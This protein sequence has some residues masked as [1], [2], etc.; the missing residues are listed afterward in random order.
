M[1]C[2]MASILRGRWAGEARRGGARNG[3]RTIA[4]EHPFED[5][6]ATFS[7]RRMQLQLTIPKGCLA[8]DQPTRQDDWRPVGKMLRQE[9]P[10]GL[11]GAI[12]LSSS[13]ALASCQTKTL[14]TEIRDE[15]DRIVSAVSF[16]ASTRGGYDRTKTA[17]AD[18]IDHK[19]TLQTV[20]VTLRSWTGCNG[21]IAGGKLRT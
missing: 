17:Q 1:M 19:A 18:L 4:R 11:S 3:R 7:S 9:S 16:C 2:L 13:F 12:V 15:A 20:L 6:G 5:C 10:P 8:Q 14:R 21:A